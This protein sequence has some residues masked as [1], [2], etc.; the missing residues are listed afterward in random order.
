MLHA[1][2]RTD[3]LLPMSVCQHVYVCVLPRHNL[4]LSFSPPASWC[5]PTL[6]RICAIWCIAGMR[7]WIWLPKYG[8][9]KQGVCLLCWGRCWPWRTRSWQ[10]LAK[11]VGGGQC[12]PSTPPHV[13][14][15]QG[16]IGYGHRDHTVVG[17]RYVR[18][19]LPY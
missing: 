15:D 3:V 14:E 10:S 6:G 9:P 12:D 19:L 7:L 1:S 4:L 13:Y 16:V 2:N 8:V 11:V 17:P 18:Y 5:Q